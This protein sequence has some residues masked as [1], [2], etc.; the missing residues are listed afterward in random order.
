MPRIASLR[1]SGPAGIW[2]VLLVVLFSCAGCA[3]GAG[4]TEAAQPQQG[5]F[6]K[7]TPYDTL[8]TVDHLRAVG[9]KMSREYDVQ[10]LPYAVGAHRAFW[11]PPGQDAKEYE[12]R[13]YA[14]HKDAVEHGTSFADEATGDNALLDEET[15]TWAEGLKDRKYFFAG[16]VGT[17]GSGSLEPKYGEF[18]IL[19]NMVLLCEGANSEH[20]LE[21]CALLVD[22]LTAAAE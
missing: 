17:H 1:T 15:A 22:A 20:G 14:S 13:L 5:P 12:V 6:Q 9:V 8:L 2:I 18:A 21:R 3:S 16:P 19:G 10:D 11:R 7:V 4:T